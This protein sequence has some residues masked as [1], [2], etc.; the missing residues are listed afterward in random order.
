MIFAVK[1]ALIGFVLIV[2]IAV[3]GVIFAAFNILTLTGNNLPEA[4]RSARCM[5]LKVDC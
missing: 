2:C 4:E 3:I 5:M 1:I